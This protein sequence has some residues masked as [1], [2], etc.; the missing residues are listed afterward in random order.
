MIA[1]DPLQ[2]IRNSRQI[3]SIWHAGKQVE[4]RVSTTTEHF[5]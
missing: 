3:V 4:P 2:N 1:D 5:D